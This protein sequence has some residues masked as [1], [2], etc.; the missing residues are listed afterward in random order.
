MPHRPT[1][2]ALSLKGHFKLSD[3]PWNLPLGSLAY[4][5]F[6]HC[7]F[8]SDDGFLKTCLYSRGFLEEPILESHLQRLPVNVAF[9]NIV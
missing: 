7:L 2:L 9:F 5:S 1:A 4:V 8:L 3:K 6:P